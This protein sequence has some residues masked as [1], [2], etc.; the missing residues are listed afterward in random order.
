M[1]APTL[2]RVL[3]VAKVT[4]Y[5]RC[6]RIEQA[7]ANGQPIPQDR[8]HDRPILPWP[9][10]FRPGRTSEGVLTQWWWGPEDV[11]AWLA[12]GDEPAHGMT[13][14]RGIYTPPNIGID[15]DVQRALTWSQGELA[16]EIGQQFGRDVCANDVLRKLLG[17]PPSRVRVARRTARH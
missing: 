16:G 5:Q 2:A 6:R 15:A 8:G 3:G 12:A 14:Y 9:P 7:I 17:L 1:T 11:T 13:R 10:L 4:V